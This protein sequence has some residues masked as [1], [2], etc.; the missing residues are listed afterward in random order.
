LVLVPA[1][2]RPPRPLG[3]SIL[4]VLQVVGGLGDVFIGILLLF[5]GLPGGGLAADASLLLG[6]LALSLGILSFILAFGL[7][8]GKGWAW[9]LGVIG[10]TIGL[11]L[12]VLGIL[13]IGIQPLSLTYLI[14]IVLY[15]L[16]LAYLNTNGVRAFFGR[17][18]RIPR[19]RPVMPPA[20]APPYPP[21]AQPE[22]QYPQT[23]QPPYYTQPQ[24]GPL[25]QPTPWGAGICPNC[26]TPFQ[27]GANFCDRC[28][29]R[30]R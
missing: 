15:A 13:V 24:Q 7:W 26:G 22:P 27:P 11:I 2:V 5:L 16:I 28:G 30:L 20:V 1:I 21:M 10:A 3:V 29:T 18:V 14:P 25:A 12:G 23:M 8:T 19:L 9:T 6:I 4:A 17:P